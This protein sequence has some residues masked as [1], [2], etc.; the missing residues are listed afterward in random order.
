MLYDVI[1]IG[2]G[3]AGMNAAVVLGRSQRKVLIFDR[4]T[5]RNARSSG[6]HNYLACDGILP[7]EFLQAASKEV[8]KYGVSFLK[9]EIVN[10][11][12]L[13][14]ELFEIKDSKENIYRAKRLLIATGVKDK[15]PKVEGFDQYYGKFIFHC[16]YCDGWEVRNRKIAVYARN[17]NGTELALALKT[18]SPDVTLL[19]DGKNLLK[20]PERKLLSKNKV[21]L[22]SDRINM[23]SG[24]KTK[25]RR[26]EFVNGNMLDCDAIFFVNGYEQQSKLA[27]ELGC[28]LGK[29]GTVL[30]NRM[31]ETNIKGLYVAGDASKDVQF[32]VV[33]AAEGAKAGVAINKD[34][35]KSEVM[36]GK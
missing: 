7:A 24:T 27:E 9:R 18:W 14:D 31:Q 30:T 5:H 36:A 11:A 6:I 21:R 1:I 29:Q 22:V 20:E 33:A 28:N 25:L 16:P 23:V 8:R 15:M 10:V 35:Q 3:P 4:G 26:V 12:K 2:G 32:V 17:K 13:A 34:L 19:T